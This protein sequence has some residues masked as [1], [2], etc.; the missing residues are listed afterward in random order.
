MPSTRH[1]DVLGAGAHAHAPI[2]QQAVAHEGDLEEE[3]AEK[4]LAVE[5]RTRTIDSQTRERLRALGY[6]DE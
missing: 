5:R 6:V 3:G 1:L 4:A 2:T